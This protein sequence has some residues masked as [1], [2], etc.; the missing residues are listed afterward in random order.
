MTNF[1]YLWFVYFSEDGI[2]ANI[3]LANFTNSDG[4]KSPKILVVDMV[5]AHASSYTNYELVL[6]LIGG[7][8]HGFFDNLIWYFEMAPCF[9]DGGCLEGIS[10]CGSILSVIALLVFTTLV[11]TT[12]V[13]TTFASF[14]VWYEP[15]HKMSISNLCL[16]SPD[17]SM[18]HIKRC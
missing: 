17:S 16:I 14:C 18:D 11:F 15:S 2:D 1:V 4:T 12:R 13:I 6:F 3:V 7:P 9:R 8:L 5:N 10:Y